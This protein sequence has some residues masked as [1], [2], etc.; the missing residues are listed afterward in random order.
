[1]TL[2]PESAMVTELEAF[3]G[4]TLDKGCAV[5]ALAAL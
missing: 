4:A 5:H 3:M 1:M 2:G